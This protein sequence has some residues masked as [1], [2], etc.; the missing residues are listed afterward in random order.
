MDKDI[1]KYIAEEK[2]ISAYKISSLEK[3]SR[4]QY[5]VRLLSIERDFL[6][7]PFEKLGISTVKEMRE[8]V[9]L[10]RTDRSLFYQKHEKTG[11]RKSF[12]ISE[13]QINLL[14]EKT[15]YYKDLYKRIIEKEIREVNI[16]QNE[17]IK[18]LSGREASS[19]CADGIDDAS[20]SEGAFLSKHRAR[21][22][23]LLYCLARFTFNKYRSIESK[24]SGDLSM[25]EYDSIR[26]SL[27]DFYAEIDKHLFENYN[28]GIEEVPLIINGTM[29]HNSFLPA[30]YPLSN[31][32]DKG[33]NEV[34]LKRLL[35][36]DKDFFTQTG[37]PIKKKK[38]ERGYGVV[39]PMRRIGNESLELLY[40]DLW[41]ESGVRLT[42]VFETRFHAHSI[43]DNYFKAISTK[44]I[45]TWECFCD[46]PYLE[47]TLLGLL[48]VSDP[49]SS[50]SLI[51]NKNIASQV[52]GSREGSVK[53]DLSLS[54]LLVPSTRSESDHI[55]EAKKYLDNQ[56]FKIKEEYNKIF[57]R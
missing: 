53:I 50:L 35:S 40:L 18:K 47:R 38:V 8:A 52:N 6:A 37:R 14:R 9:S 2:D 56:V 44:P 57:E 42:N 54:K 48:G 49:L 45:W 33:G 36:E 27:D 34:V 12:A 30:I 19:F 51:N 1:L 4:K 20:S 17:Y 3:G 10:F 43:N 22:Q 28:N 31:L 55:R 11:H 21:I 25:Q 39:T 29:G 13:S 32:C 24:I 7:Y 41:S 15:S 16:I 23:I 26:G 46:N 5:K